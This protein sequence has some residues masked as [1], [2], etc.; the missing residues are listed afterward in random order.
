MASRFFGVFGDAAQG[1]DKDEQDESDAADAPVETFS[2]TILTLQGDSW[3]IDGL[4]SDHTVAMLMER[5]QE[6]GRFVATVGLAHGTEALGH[7]QR[8]LTLGAAG[9]SEGAT[10]TCIKL[11]AE[12]ALGDQAFCMIGLPPNG[13]RAEKSRVFLE[14]LRDAYLSDYRWRRQTTAFAHNAS[15]AREATTYDQYRDRTTAYVNDYDTRRHTVSAALGAAA[16]RRADAHDASASSDIVELYRG[17]CRTVGFAAEAAAAREARWADTTCW[18]RSSGS[19]ATV[20][21]QSQSGGD[22]ESQQHQPLLGPIVVDSG[23][24][25]IRAGLAGKE[26]P[27]VE[28][29]C[30]VGRPAGSEGSDGS[31]VVVGRAAMPAD[32]SMVP[33]CPMECGIVVDWGDMERVWH[34]VFYNELAVDPQRHPVLLSEPL[35]NPRANRERAAA[36]LFGAFRVPMVHFALSAVLALFFVQRRTTSVMVDLGEGSTTI[37]PIYETFAV[38]HA[39]ARIDI[40]GRDLTE[41][42]MRRLRESCAGLEIKTAL[43]RESI[44]QLKEKHCYVAQDFD[45]EYRRSLETGSAEQL[46]RHCTLPTP[47]GTGEAAVTLGKER[48]CSPEALFQPLLLGRAEP[49]LHKALFGAV[50]ASEIDLRRNL[51]SNIVLSGGTAAMEG[52]SERLLKE[53]RALAPRSMKVRIVTPPKAQLPYGT[54]IG[55]SVLASHRGYV[56]WT[57]RGHFGDPS[58][59]YER[60]LHACF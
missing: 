6:E 27:A 31:E 18:P 29:P 5:V 32:G 48:F 19:T 49:G 11:A 17:R 42:L 25:T 45:E 15:I 33:T 47:L 60:S 56:S 30:L 50:M 38:L 43:Q 13:E 21:D 16:G 52:L 20:V 53:L 55:G 39:A 35:L 44:C 3:R 51:F 1:E 41:D 34:H 7:R 57:E 8:D 12:E 58:T 23:T 24:S 26:R 54:W 14:Q 2:V 28:L 37:L 4:Q 10:L 22:E 9:I 36:V 46:V 59:G 40:A